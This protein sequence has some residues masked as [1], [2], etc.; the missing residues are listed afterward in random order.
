[1]SK[2]V[3]GED[4]PS[5][6]LGPEM[7]RRRKYRPPMGEMP[8]ALRPP[9]P[10]AAPTKQVKFVE[11]PKPKAKGAVPLAPG[12]CPPWAGVGYKPK[13]LSL[14]PPPKI[15]H[16]GKQ[17]RPRVDYA[18]AGTE[19]YNDP[20]TYPWRCVCRVID[21]GIG[22]RGSGVLIGPRHVLTASHCVA[23]NSSNA[24]QVEVHRAGGG[25]QATAFAEVAFAYTQIV[26]D[27]APSDQLDEDYAV[28]V[29]TERLGDRFGWLGCR[30]Y[31]SGW[32]GDEVWDSMGYAANPLETFPVFQ[33]AH[34]LDEDDFDFG[35]ARAMTTS[36]DVL[37]GYS[38]SPMFGTWDDGV[39][40][41]AVISSDDPPENENWCA[42]GS[43]LLELVNQAR[44]EHP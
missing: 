23:W 6:P 40:V 34:W 1:M 7:L 24:E 14:P 28:L 20:N 39:Y 21:G 27:S 29:L 15:F 25:F 3:L 33:Q 13:R 44:A 31:D 12:F 17:L 38:G 30:E 41:V 18:P 26:G 9:A 19:S 2:F 5:L 4:D 35:S 37:D 32:D 10:P 42:G 22:K 36:A 11:R 16:R 43:D 8:A